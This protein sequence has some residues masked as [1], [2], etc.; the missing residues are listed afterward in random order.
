MEKAAMAGVGQSS[1]WYGCLVFGSFKDSWF[2]VTEA[3]VLVT[4]GSVSTE[5]AKF[6]LR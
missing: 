1:L 5:A 2:C 6:W 4:L 3:A